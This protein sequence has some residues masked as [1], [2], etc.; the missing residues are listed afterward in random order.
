MSN[1]RPHPPQSRQ[2][3]VLVVDDGFEIRSI[4]SAL[5]RPDYQVLTAATGPEALEFALAEPRPDLILLDV[6]L[7]LMDGYEVLARLKELPETC[8]IPVVFITMR[9]GVEEVVRGLDHGAADYITK[10]LCA[11]I[12]MARVRTQMELKRSRDW[13]KDQNAALEAEVARRVE[14]CL[15][16]QDVSIFTLARLAEARDE[17]TGNHLRRTQ[18]YVRVLAEGLV[19]H[20]RFAGFLGG[21]N[22]ETL[23]KSALLHDIGKIGIPDHILL[24]PGKLSPLEREIMQTHAKLGRDAIELAKRDAVKPVEFLDMAQEIAYYHHEKWDGT[25]YPVGLSGESI[26][27]PARLMAMADVFD[28]LI[29]NRHYKASWSFEQARELIAQERERHFDPD[30]VDAFLGRFDDFK[31]IAERYADQ[32]YMRDTE[33]IFSLGN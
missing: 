9:N 20:P 32:A 14:E 17:V 12:V 24:K 21:G 30:V 11:P 23:T 25:G 4:L 3:V 18:H 22:I 5:L 33:I 13:L 26:P 29:S 27:I 31:A 7:P 28:A 6:V 2:P 10:P 16:I 8:D 1:N 19:S 15:L